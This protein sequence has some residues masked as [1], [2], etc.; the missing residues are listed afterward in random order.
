[1]EMS[2]KKLHLLGFVA[3]VAAVFLSSWVATLSPNW[4]FLPMFVVSFLFA[5]LFYRNQAPHMWFFL[6]THLLAFSVYLLV[7]YLTQGGG[8]GANEL[9]LWFSATLVY[10]SASIPVFPVSMAYWIYMRR[11]QRYKNNAK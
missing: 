10:S 8:Q 6:L 3:Q 11:M 1:M 7:N 2:I 9:P 4:Y 5:W